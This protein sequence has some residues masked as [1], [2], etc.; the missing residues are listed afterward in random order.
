MPKMVLLDDSIH[1]DLQI[2]KV[3]LSNGFVYGSWFSDI[4]FLK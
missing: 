4:V 1:A 2:P 3:I